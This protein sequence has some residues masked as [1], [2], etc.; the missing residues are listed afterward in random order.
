MTSL[1]SV[2]MMTAHSFLVRDMATC[3]RVTVH[4]VYTVYSRVFS[5]ECRTWC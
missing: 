5:M 1:P 4:T 3:S 2:S